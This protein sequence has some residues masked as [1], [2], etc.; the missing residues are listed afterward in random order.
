MAESTLPVD[1][2]NPGQVFACLG[3]LEGADV[4]LGAAKGAFDWSG[5]EEVL[6]RVS[7]DG[8]EPPVDRILRFLEAAQVVARVPHAS[9]SLGGIE[10][11]SKN[12]DETEIDPPDHPFPF[13]DPGKPGVLPAVLREPEGKALPVDYWGDTTRR[14]NVK[15]WGGSAGYPGA[16][17][18]RDALEL[19]RPD[20]GQQ[21]R[22]PFA[23]TEVQSSSFRFDWRRDNLPV[24]D[25]FSVNRHK[26]TILMVGFPLVEILA[27][28]GLT[29]A[30]P[31]CETRLEYIYGILGQDERRLLLAPEFHRAALGG[32][33][34]PLPGVPFR[35]FRM[36]LERPDGKSRSITQV[37]EEEIVR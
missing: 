16:A 18:L 26:S 24:H 11:W 10:K 15:F 20:V 31:R 3:I 17:L 5:G 13:R 29:H 34:S 7:T 14:D 6:F 23:F 2:L 37:H 35:Q 30:R 32:R 22:D 1:L 21:A 25:G 27:A 4:L 8:D 12:W 36:L 33:Q 9:P 19:C 28:V